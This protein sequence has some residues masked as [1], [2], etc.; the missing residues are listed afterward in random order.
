M[1]RTLT[2]YLNKIDKLE[3]RIDAQIDDLLKVIDLDLLLENPKPYMN[4]LSKQFFESLEDELTEAIQA[5]EDK[6]NQIVNSIK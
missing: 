2:N 5:G 4:E 6:A 1:A 3:E